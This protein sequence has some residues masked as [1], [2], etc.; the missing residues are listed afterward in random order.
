MGCDLIA[1]CIKNDEGGLT[2]S[3]RQPIPAKYGSYLVPIISHSL[4]QSI[5]NKQ[6]QDTV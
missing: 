3:N 5:L 2:K 1:I 6:G 4:I